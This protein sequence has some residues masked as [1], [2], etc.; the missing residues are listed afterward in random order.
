MSMDERLKV[1]SCMYG[2]HSEL[3]KHR[4]ESQ[5]TCTFETRQ[6]E[7]ACEGCSRRTP[8]DEQKGSE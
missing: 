2:C 1:K 6:T 8:N 4:I 7:R 3:D 5:R